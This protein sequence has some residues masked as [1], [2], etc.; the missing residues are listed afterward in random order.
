M[1]QVQINEQMGRH[2]PDALGLFWLDG[3]G[4]V[5]AEGQLLG[6]GLLDE[7]RRQAEYAQRY[8]KVMISPLVQMRSGAKVV[9]EVP[10]AIPRWA[11][12]ATA[13]A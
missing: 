5:H 1:R 4:S 8:K 12:Q 11:A 9:S 13:Q 10:L 7:E 3:A 6:N 2:I